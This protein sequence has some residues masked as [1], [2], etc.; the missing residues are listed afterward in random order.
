MSTAA[1]RTT[2][3]L[4]N[5]LRELTKKPVVLVLTD[6]ASTMLSKKNGVLRAH[7]MFLTAPEPVLAALADFF[8]TGRCPAAAREFINANTRQISRATPRR[9]ALITQGKTYDL[10]AIAT[11]INRDY[12]QGRSAAPLTWGREIL[13]RRARRTLLGY[14]DPKKNIITISRRLDCAAVPRYFVEYVVF[15]EMLHE[16]LGIG[17]RPDGKRDIHSHTFRTLEQTFPLYGEA[18]KFERSYF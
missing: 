7:K 13:R 11:A 4:Q 8:L 14:Y 6:N 18:R 2:F 3:T 9:R 12:L 17:E 5:R 15:H 10:T 1:P 16:I